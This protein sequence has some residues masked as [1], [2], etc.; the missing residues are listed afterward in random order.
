M[1][2]AVWFIYSKAVARESILCMKGIG[3]QIERQHV[4]GA[5]EVVFIDRGCIEDVLIN[6]G[7]TACRVVFFLE[8]LAKNQTD[9]VVLFQDF[10]P[11]LRTLKVIRDTI[12]NT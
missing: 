12:L 6:E 10:L 3:I 2:M 9:A 8:I 11:P 1:L 4:I 7:F 5:K